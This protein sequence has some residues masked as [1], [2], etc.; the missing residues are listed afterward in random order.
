MNGKVKKTGGLILTERGSFY[1]HLYPTPE[2]EFC[3]ESKN[4][5]VFPEVLYQNVCKKMSVV[6]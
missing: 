3:H 5:Q 4:I 6:S 2:A 1:A